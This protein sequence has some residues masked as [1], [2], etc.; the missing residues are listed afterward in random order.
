MTTRGQSTGDPGEAR[1]AAWR[2]EVESA[3]GRW[4]DEVA[5]R[6]GCPA[7][8]AE[9]MRYALLGG[10][11]RLR[12]LLAMGAAAAVSGRPEAACEA[13]VAVE[14]VHAY[15][16]VHDDL[17]A[18]D[19]DDFRRGRPT[20]HRRFGQALA[21]LAGD[22]LLSL[23]FEVL[24]RAFPDGRAGRAVRILAEAAGPAGM[25]GGQA[26]D[27]RPW[28]GE[29]L[30]LEEVESVHRRKT[31]CLIAAATSLG[32]LAAGA[33]DE[34]LQA[35]LRH[36]RALGLAFQVADD[37]LSAIGDAAALGRPGTTDE[38]KDRRL[39][40]RLAGLEASRA[41]GHALL[42]EARAALAPFVPPGGQPAGLLELVESV[43]ARLG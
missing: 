22:G 16:L 12:P 4:M 37:V 3:L 1:M 11:K 42:A 14:L 40:P 15:S 5:A 10:G 35:L 29:P 21:I 6:P 41:R 34:A 13:G 25:V 26:D 33:D 23:A 8:L 43:A 32:G 36:G 2:A 17:P 39:H 30:Q 18:M 38:R 24:A 27:V 28:A 31:G 20:C 9:A 19:D 7:D